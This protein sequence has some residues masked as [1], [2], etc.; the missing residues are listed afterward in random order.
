MSVLKAGPPWEVL[1]VND[2][3]EEIHATPALSGGRIYVRARGSIC[4]FGE[5]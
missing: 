5:P 1:R 4:C 2:L 3:G